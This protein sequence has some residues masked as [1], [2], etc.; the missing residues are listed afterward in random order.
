[1][2][3]IAMKILKLNIIITVFGLL[4]VTQ[5]SGKDFKKVE[6]LRGYWYFK[7]GD[8]LIWSEINYDHSNW[9]EIYVPEPWEDEGYHGY[10]GY[11]WYRKEF[12][13]DGRYLKNSLYL[14][15]GMIDDV[16][17]IFLNGRKIGAS[18]I[19]PPNIK[20]AYN[21]KVWIPIPE[22]SIKSGKNLLAVRV[23]DRGGVGGIYTGDVALYSERNPLELEINLAGDWKFKTGDSRK[24]KETGYDDSAWE[25]Q[26]V[27]GYWDHQGYPLY[28]GFAWYRKSFVVNSK[29]NSNDL[30]VV[31]GKI[32]DIDQVYLNGKMIGSTGDMI[33]SPLT[34]TF[35][36][37]YQLIRGYYINRDDL[38]D[39]E[40]IIAVRVYDG[41]ADGGI[42]EGPVGIAT[43]SN[44]I[45]Y[46]STSHKK[47]KSF[48]ERLFEDK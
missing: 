21:V 26:M 8:N 31:L 5:L 1:M 10:D 9:D 36:S 22:G 25:L 29:F 45:D 7:L 14:S 27:P 39:G 48:F 32:D 47:T 20:T 41:L 43:L 33:M 38:K 4:S 23:F 34:N 28:D 11:A 44:Y 3:S 37:E 2:I 19:F 6:D 15:L 18:G 17:E 35:Y 16:A 13:I 40:N 24:R 30:V 42:Y 46:R 12:E